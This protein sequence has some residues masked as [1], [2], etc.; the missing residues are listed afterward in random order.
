M[1][2]KLFS[3]FLTSVLFSNSGNAFSSETAEETL[4][5]LLQLSLGELLEIPVNVSVASSKDEPI[6]LTPAI[7]SSYAVDDM[8]KLGLRTLQDIL[9]FIPGVIVQDGLNGNV[10]VMIRGIS[11]GFNQKAL[12]VLDDVPY[13]MTPHGDMP[14]LGIPIEGIEKVEVIRGPGA[15]Y[16]GTNASGG[17]IKIITRKS[18]E[19][20]VAVS[21]GSNSLF[22]TGGNLQYAWGNSNLSVSYE[23][24]NDEGYEGYIGGTESIPAGEINKQN[25]IKSILANYQFK[26]FKLMGSAFNTVGSGIAERLWPDNENDLEYDSYLIHAQQ[27]LFFDKTALKFFADYNRYY[28]QFYTDN[29]LGNDYDGG[30]RFD[31]HDENY[32]LRGGMNVDYFF[33][34]TVS[35]FF[36]AEYEKRS[37]GDYVG[38]NDDTDATMFTILPGFAQEEYSLYGQLDVL[39]WNDLRLVA[40]GRYTNNKDLGDQVTPRLSAVYRIDNTQSIKLLYSEGFNTPSLTQQGADMDPVIVGNPDLESETVETVDLAYS[41]VT[42]KTMFVANVFYMHAQDFILKDRTSGTIRFFNAGDFERCGGELDFK[43]CLNNT[44]SF[45]ANMAY[46]YQ[47]DSDDDYAAE[48]VPK[49]TTSLGVSWHKGHHQVGTSLRA[50]GKRAESSA[51]EQVNVNYQYSRDNWQLYLTLKNVLDEEIL[52][53]NVGDFESRELPGGD[54]FNFLAGLKYSF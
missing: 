22:N 33:T 13:W 5:S 29:F 6:I 41:L 53:P 7:V 45:L 24:Q 49:L 52:N 11:E 38:Y 1:K 21:A 42:P 8:A 3:L 39:L 16:Y 40:G 18:G 47:G 19:S 51:Y 15:I 2:K 12:F 46:Q 50:I 23:Y 17:V 32:R 30:F 9:S 34:P 25:D 37:T 27:Q 28:L 44:W 48:F 14:L 4:D 10:Q 35:G 26:D 54:D 43:Y 20:R 36:G 31:D